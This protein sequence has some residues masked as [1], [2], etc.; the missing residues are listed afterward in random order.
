MRWLL[1]NILTRYQSQYHPVVQFDETT[2]KLLLLDLTRANRE[3]SPSLVND[4][5]LFS[6]YISKKLQ[7]AKAKYAIGGYNE[8]R[9]V[10]SRSVV[11]DADG[12][13]EEPRRL[14]LGTDIWGEAGT[15]VYAPM[16]GMVHSFNFNNNFGDYGATIIL[17]HQLDGFP[18]YTLYGHLSLRDIDHL[19]EGQYVIR[20]EEIAHFGTPEE[21]GN[22]PPH[23]HFQLIYD[24]G[25]FRGDYP[26]VCKLSEKSKW[27][28]NSP[29]PDVILQM[30][31][32][33]GNYE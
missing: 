29:D 5:G 26:G 20:G 19:S 17:L 13:G 9:T 18:F 27:L 10:Y 21:N 7:L 14:H 23:L 31:K 4:T 3:L 24:M 28:S 25:T 1:N 22:W 12:S 2:D 32:F 33:L 30:N 6:A 16:G 11:F 8:H 15:P